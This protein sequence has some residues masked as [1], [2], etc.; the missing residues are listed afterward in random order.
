MAVV[1]IDKRKIV[2]KIIDEMTLFDDDL[3]SRVFDA[4]IGATEL[5]LR[6]ILERDDI[7]VISVHGQEEL[8]NP[9]VG[10]RNITLDILAKDKAGQVFDVEVQR[11]TEGSHVRRARF[12]S[13]SVDTRILKE[14]EGFKTLKDSYVIFIC[15][16][17]KFKESLPIYHIDRI[18]RETNEKFDDGSHII[19]VNGKYEGNDP[20]GKLVHDFSCKESKDMYYGEL[21][22]GVKHYKE[23]EE[24]RERM[25]ESVKKFAYELAE[26]A[27]EKA[28]KEQQIESF[29]NALKKG[30]SVTDAQEIAGINDELV[31]EI[32]QESK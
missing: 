15:E 11:N 14:K 21:A 23:T 13:S 25:C 18:V 27:A 16:H 9:V 29:K 28:A 12:H 20:I 26:E 32:L 22:S 31:A 24:G 1:D 30:L 4:N 8:K 3:M 10:G 5:L 6:I 2:E 19:Y 17:D 7:E